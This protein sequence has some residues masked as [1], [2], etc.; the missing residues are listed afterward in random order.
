MLHYAC[1]DA[2]ICREYLRISNIEILKMRFSK[3]AGKE[4]Q[5]LSGF[6][7]FVCEG[8]RWKEGIGEGERDRFWY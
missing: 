5:M 6:T 3:G 7:G 2:G 1:K 8:E 4:N